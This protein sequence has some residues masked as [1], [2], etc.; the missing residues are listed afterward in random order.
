MSNVVPQPNDVVSTI[1]EQH[2]QARQLIGT[3]KAAAP[4]ARATPFGELAEM[5]HA[6]E[7]A[8]QSVVYPALRELG[9]EGERVVQ[10][11]ISEEEQASQVLAEL[12]ASDPSTPA[13][14]ES[15]VAFSGDVEQHARNEEAEVLPLLE[16]FDDARRT[17]LGDAFASQTGTAP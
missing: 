12:E 17:E 14:E 13:F 4:E 11:R 9:D 6:H 1:R 16:K 5:L 8:E 10:Q 3:I 2:A 15:F 7:A